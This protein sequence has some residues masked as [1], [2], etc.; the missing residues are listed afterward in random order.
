VFCRREVADAG[1]GPHLV[2]VPPP[3][4]EL[5]P[6]VG[7]GAEQGLVEQFVAQAAVEALAEAVLLGIAEG[8]VMSGDLASSAHCRMALQVS[9]LP[10]SLTIM[11]G[12]PRQAMMASSSRATR[13][14]EIEVSATSAKHSRVQSS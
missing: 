4:L 5:G 3:G 7:Q 13:W 6:G 1:V 12:L 9:S 10:L 11:V 2:V 8:G 14:P